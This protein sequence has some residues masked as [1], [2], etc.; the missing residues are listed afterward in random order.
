MLLIVDD[1]SGLSRLGKSIDTLAFSGSNRTIA[2]LIF[3]PRTGEN[4]HHW[5]RPIKFPD[6][7]DISPHLG[8]RIIRICGQNDQLRGRGPGFQT[9]AMEFSEVRQIGA[10]AQMLRRKITAVL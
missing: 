3:D 9:I 5:L 2:M 1:S 7:L 10:V 8:F 4:R 6:N